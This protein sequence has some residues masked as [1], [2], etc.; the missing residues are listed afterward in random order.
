MWSR[1]NTPQSS[2]I[3]Q[4][5]AVKH[6]NQASPGAA[7]VQ[8]PRHCR[9]GPSGPQPSHGHSASPPATSRPASRLCPPTAPRCDPPGAGPPKSGPGTATPTASFAS[10]ELKESRLKSIKPAPPAPDE[11]VRPASGCPRQRPPGLQLDR[12]RGHSH[13]HSLSGQSHPASRDNAG[14]STI[15]TPRP[16]LA[17]RPIPGFDKGQIFFTRPGMGKGAPCLQLE[18]VQGGGTGRSPLGRPVKP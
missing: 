2:L 16:C 9:S 10:L 8:R 5:R 18:L 15:S 17:L 11:G 1:A 13:G 14:I 12:S 4:L 7:D 6:D 3:R